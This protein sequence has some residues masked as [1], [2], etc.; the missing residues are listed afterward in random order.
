MLLPGLDLYRAGLLAL[1]GF[2]QLFLRD[3]DEYQKMSHHLSAEPLH[4]ATVW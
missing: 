1:W 3:I 2:S 4:C